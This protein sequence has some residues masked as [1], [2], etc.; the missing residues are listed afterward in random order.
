MT[1]KSECCMDDLVML[2]FKISGILIKHLIRFGWKKGILLGIEV[3]CNSRAFIALNSLN[4]LELSSFG[5]L[6]SIFLLLPSGLHFSVVIYI[7]L[8]PTFSFT[9]KCVFL[10]GKLA[11]LSLSMA[12]NYEP[13]NV[14]M[15]RGFSFSLGEI[16]LF[17]AYSLQ[18]SWVEL[19]FPG[20]G[21][22]IILQHFSL[23]GSYLS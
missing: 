11:I 2:R 17:Q 10:P 22:A 20:F 5:H 8:I 14:G 21:C 12:L 23:N 16:S 6:F 1:W 15:G 3:W 18:T 7:F 4:V 13:W 19:I 9:Q